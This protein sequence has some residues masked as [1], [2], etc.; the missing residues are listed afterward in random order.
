[1]KNFERG[2]MGVQIEE[3]VIEGNGGDF[4]LMCKQTEHLSTSIPVVLT[5]AHGEKEHNICNDI[6]V[7]LY[8][9][10]PIYRINL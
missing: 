4:N 6:F 10:Q 2:Q 3:P 8:F 5:L 9:Y 1:M 7:N